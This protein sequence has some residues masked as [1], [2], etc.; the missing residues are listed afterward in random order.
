MDLPR[1]WRAAW[2]A[3]Q[4]SNERIVEVE[5]SREGRRGQRQRVESHLFIVAQAHWSDQRHAIPRRAARID[6]IITLKAE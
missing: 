1:V 5:G 2:I 6:P 3:G 4:L